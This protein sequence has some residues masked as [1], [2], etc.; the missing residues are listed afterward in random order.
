M[1]MTLNSYEYKLQNRFLVVEF[2]KN[3]ICGEILHKNKHVASMIHI[4]FSYL[5]RAFLC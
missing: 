3:K 5:K 2:Q 4:F 1:A